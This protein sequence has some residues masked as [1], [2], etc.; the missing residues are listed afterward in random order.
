MLTRLCPLLLLFLLLQSF[1][2]ASPVD[3]CV[4]VEGRTRCGSGFVYKGLIITCEHVV[5][6]DQIFKVTFANGKSI[7]CRVAYSNK[8]QDIAVLK[9]FLSRGFVIDGLPRGEDITQV[10]EPV[11]MVGHSSVPFMVSFGIVGSIQE[12][13]YIIDTRGYLGDSGSPVIDSEGRVV[14][15]MQQILVTELGGGHHPGYVVILKISEIDKW[16]ASLEK[17]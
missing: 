13:E 8:E 16:L 4:M 12:T 7:P 14:G 6:E 9:P 2:L 5:S 11:F 10:P 15:M 1:C 17:S 3:S